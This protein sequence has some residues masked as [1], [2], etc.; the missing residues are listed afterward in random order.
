MRSYRIMPLNLTS[1]AIMCRVLFKRG[2]L[3]LIMSPGI[4]RC[5][6]SLGRPLSVEPVVS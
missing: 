1:V 3:E 4:D 5:N 2:P 6:I